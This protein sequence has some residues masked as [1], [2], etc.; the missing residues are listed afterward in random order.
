MQTKLP[1]HAVNISKFITM[2]I[3]YREYITDIMNTVTIIIVYN[4]LLVSVLLHS[5]YKKEQVN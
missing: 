3:Y 1:V 5:D 4:K 2:T